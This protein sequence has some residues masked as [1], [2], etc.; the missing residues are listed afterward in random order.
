M[1][2]QPGP[3]LQ[4]A[5]GDASFPPGVYDFTHDAQALS[6]ELNAI[7]AGWDQI[8]IDA[9]NLA[10]DPL[11][12]LNAIDDNSIADA[13][14][15]QTTLTGFPELD[16]A[17]GFYGDGDMQLDSAVAFAPMQ[18]WQN[19]PSAFVPPG[20]SLTLHA[21]TI[22]P[23]SF[24]P[25]TTG[26]VGGTGN[27]QKP[28]VQ[29][30]NFTRVGA[31][32]FVVGDTFELAFWGDP[33]QQISVGG[34]FNGVAFPITDYDV[35]S[36]LGTLGKDGVMGPGQVGAWHEDW[37]FDGSLVTSFDFVVAPGD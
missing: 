26:T 22:D 9:A 36:E 37:Y 28:N 8:L 34:S 29:F 10:A 35:L 12:D 20:A 7:A 18:A 31:T 30:W 1:S 5:E 25:A 33:G 32:N 16:D 2:L 24:N 13:V 6:D 19:P 21:P 17:V 4:Q 3:F 23:G 15:L 27:Y 11:D 14:A